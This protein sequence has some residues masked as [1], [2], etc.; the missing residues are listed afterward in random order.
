MV[1]VTLALFAV[2]LFVAVL[3]V[4]FSAEDIALPR[5]AKR[6]AYRLFLSKLDD[7]QRRSWM[8]NRRFDVTARSGRSYTIFSYDAFNVYSCGEEFCVQID[9]RI[10]VYDKLL[11]Q[12]LLLKADEQRF[13][14]LANKR[15]CAMPEP[16]R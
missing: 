7:E 16:I 4:V 9:E 10:P 5:S 1:A 12:Q 13:L 6:R 3:A 14:R 2:T 8:K 11:A 15:S